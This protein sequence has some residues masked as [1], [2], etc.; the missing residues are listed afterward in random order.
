MNSQI[1]M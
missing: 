1:S